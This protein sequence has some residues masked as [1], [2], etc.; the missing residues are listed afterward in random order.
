[1][2]N[3]LRNIGV[4]LFLIFM[5]I[6]FPLGYSL[7]D[8]QYQLASDLNVEIKTVKSLTDVTILKLL[9]FFVVELFVG[10]IGVFFIFKEKVSKNYMDFDELLD[11]ESNVVVTKERED[12]EQK[13]ILDVDGMVSIVESLSDSISL[14]DYAKEIIKEV[15]KLLEASQGV[16]F[17][18]TKDEEGSKK[19]EVFAGYAYYKEDNGELVYRFGEGLAGQ[20]AKAQKI[21]NI[22]NVP[23]G[24]IQIISGLGQAS[25]RN[26]LIVPLIRKGKTVGVMELASFKDFSKEQED[27]LARISEIVSKKVHSLLSPKKEV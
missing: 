2:K 9:G 19:L 5:I 18:T 22:K 15:S 11:S 3:S 23:D 20:A 4:F 26:L 7:Y 16:F 17:L 12:K 6:I 21:I 25:P 10:G 8:L 13:S 1:M 24:Y 27:V 14:K